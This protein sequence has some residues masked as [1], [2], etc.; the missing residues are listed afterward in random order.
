MNRDGAVNVAKCAK[1]VGSKLLFLSSDYVFDG[2]KTS[3]Y[4][5]DDARNPQSVY[6]RSKAEAEVQL[7][8]IFLD[9]ALREH[10]GC[11]EPA[12]SAFPIRF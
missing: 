9:A 12:A 11:L 6:G 8:E 5:T 1:H 2:K 7:L 4:E 3:P 10:L